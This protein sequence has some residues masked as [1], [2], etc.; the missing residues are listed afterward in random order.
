MSF[1]LRD[2]SAASTSVLPGPGQA[3]PFAEAK[4]APNKRLFPLPREADR[5][6]TALDK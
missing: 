5:N 4:G 3:K 2:R 1:R 6:F